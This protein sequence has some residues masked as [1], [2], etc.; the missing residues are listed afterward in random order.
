MKG[1]TPEEP[2]NKKRSPFEDTVFPNSLTGIGGTRGVKPTG[3]GKKRGNTGLID[4][5]QCIGYAPQ[6]IE[7]SPSQKRFFRFP[8]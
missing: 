6:L 4:R 5:D 2:F 3:R 1:M 8:L 7:K